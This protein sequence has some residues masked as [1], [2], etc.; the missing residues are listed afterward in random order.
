MKTRTL[1]SGVL[2][3][4]AP[5]SLAAQGT[6]PAGT[7][8][9]PERESPFVA[10]NL[11]V[12]AGSQNDPKGKE[13]LAALTA[14]LLAE[15]ST[16]LDP[17]E[18]I[19]AKL[20]PMAAGYDYS[21]DKEMTVFRGR[22][23]RDHLEA[24]YM[25]LRN[26]L[27]TPAFA[28]DDFERVKA[29]T[30]N[31]LER[32][33]RFARDEE[34][35]KELLYWMAFRGTPYQ[36]PEEGYVASVRSITLDDVK[37]F[38]RTVYL[39]NNVVVGLGGGY[40]PGLLERVRADM[41]ALPAG[42]V[43]SVPRSV[44]TM[45]DGV[46]VLIVEKQ[47]DAT[48]ISLGFPTA[49]LRGRADF[50]AL[51]AANAWF[52][53]HRNSLSHLYQ[54]IREARGMNY[55]DYSYIEAFPLGY[56]TQEPPVNVSRRSQLFEIWIRPI[57][58]TAAPD[59]HE[60]ALFATR[61]AWRELA[62]LVDDGMTDST[63][64]E[65]TGYLHNFSVTYGSTVSRRLA[66]AVDDAFYGLTTG[67]LA[68]IRPGL[69]TLTLTGVNGAISRNLQHANMYVVFI[70][71]DAEGLK[72]KLLSGVPT[73]ITYAGPKSAAHMAEDAEIAAFP[74]PVKAENI[75]IINITEVFER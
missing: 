26:A 38:Y 21:V 35:S 44:A 41:D 47:T 22:V 9:L 33:R 31:F 57:S 37:Q 1:L 48:A 56:T 29:Q 18:R 73:P 64:A 10:F 2:I 52:G 5:T 16:T 17:Y 69:A 70:T 42:E 30:L 66:Y 59:L 74:I 15:G 68:S 40:P 72:Q 65:A 71:Q 45:P 67:H 14:R 39:R 19:L 6:A 75:T 20:Y 49:L 53:E 11:W 34:L 63:L 24:Y 55:G 4:M 36:H 13:G 60:R 12:K 58:K 27:L 50:F 51:M 8:A 25:L 61:A 23:H 3:A 43:A 54:V 7:I 28:P 46:H 32:S 62:K